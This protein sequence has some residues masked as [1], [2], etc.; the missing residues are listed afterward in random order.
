MAY[1]IVPW[2]DTGGEYIKEDFEQWLGEFGVSHLR[3]SEFRP[4]PSPAI[5][6]TPVLADFSSPPPASGASRYILVNQ[7]IA[8]KIEAL[9]P[10]VHDFVALEYRYGEED[11]YTSY[12]YFYV[13]INNLG[14]PT[15]HELSDVK[16]FRQRSN[17][18]KK[19]GVPLVL[20]REAIAG[21]HLMF[22][23]FLVFISDEFHDWIVDNGLQGHWSF[24]RQ[25][26]N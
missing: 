3:L 23:P 8:K 21:K 12:P 17:W 1:V 6:R 13:R 14:D 15:D 24:E 19:P 9:E 7:L 26:A 10:G 2:G 16:V 25:V 18:E 5:I 11:N 4:L 20:R 22:H